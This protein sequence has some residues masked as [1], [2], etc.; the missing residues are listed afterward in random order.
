MRSIE[1]LRDFSK[2]LSEGKERDMVVKEN[3]LFVFYQFQNYYQQN[4]PSSQIGDEDM[5][6]PE[7]ETE[8]D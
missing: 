4:M 3:S 2:C 5:L 1:E 7:A 8:Q 6:S